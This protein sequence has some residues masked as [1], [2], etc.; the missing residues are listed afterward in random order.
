MITSINPRCLRSACERRGLILVK[1]RTRLHP[2][3]DLKDGY[4]ILSGRDG[5][6]IE[7][8]RF[9]LT[10]ENVRDYLNALDAKED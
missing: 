10:E 8:H 2:C 6:I 4:Q 7:G 5:S 9:E 3:L 1:A